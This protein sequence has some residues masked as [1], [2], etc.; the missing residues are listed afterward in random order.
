MK[1]L[2]ISLLMM[3]QLLV[4]AAFAASTQL[5]G[6]QTADFIFDGGFDSG[7][8]ELLSE[9][10]MTHTEG[11]FLPAYFG[12]LA[13]VVTIDLALAGFYWGVYVPTVYT[14]SLSSYQT[15]DR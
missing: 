5:G 13:A 6:V 2:L 7:K 9:A 4:P 11:E 10:E 12:Y 1:K 14:Q 8:V 15:Y 3:V